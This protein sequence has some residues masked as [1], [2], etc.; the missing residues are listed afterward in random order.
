[1]RRR[2]VKLVWSLEFARI[3]EA[4]SLEKRLQGWSRAKRRAL[5]DGRI[6][7][8]RALAGRSYASQDLR[9][10]V[11][12]RQLDAVDSAGDEPSSG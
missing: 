4:Y 1:M 5:I 9:S 7:D 12:G 10:A 6:D 3:D 2:P 8:I 11:R